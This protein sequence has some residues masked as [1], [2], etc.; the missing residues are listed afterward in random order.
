MITSYATLQTAVSDWL[1][2]DDLTGG[3]STFVQSAEASL[4]RDGR[5]RRLVSEDFPVDRDIEFLPPRF[6]AL[7]A[8]YLSVFGRKSSL[9]VL[10]LD[11]LAGVGT[12]TAGQ[13][14]YVALTG[15]GTI[16][17]SPAPDQLYDYTMSYWQ[18]FPS[19]SDEEPQNWLLTDHPD[20]YLYATLAETAPFLYDDARVPVWEAALESRLESLGRDNQRARY[21]G[22]VHVQPS[23]T[24]G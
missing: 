22:P 9:K 23:R 21:S 7:D 5:A 6:A 15:E 3:M 20:I 8:I 14:E 17:F 16:K 13:P 24:I 11:A 4:R 2:Q 12:D 1:D 10:S 18:T 19:L